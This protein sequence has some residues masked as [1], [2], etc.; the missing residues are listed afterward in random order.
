MLREAKAFLAIW[1]DIDPAMAAEWHRWHSEEHMA[2]RVAIPG[3]LAGRRYMKLA[4]RDQVCFT[5]Y[6]GRDLAVFASP[7]YRARLDAP[8]PWTRRMAPAFRNLVRGACRRIASA[9]LEKGDG[10][11]LLTTRLEG[12]LEGA[13][14]AGGVPAAEALV[15][16]I[17]GLDGMVG[18][19]LGICEPE[20]T[21]RETRERALRSGTAETSFD[22]VVIVEAYDSAMLEEAAAEIESL[23]AAAG[24]GL[25]PL[26][27]QTY[28]LAFMLRA[29]A[30]PPSQGPWPP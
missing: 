5:L 25:R 11:A 6:E 4:A 29:P 2:E 7:A 19:H 14:F 18:A 1:H 27:A 30:G 20:V 10:G 22:G 15:A 17:A 21:E 28:G 12:C 26:A 9:G 3:F 24:L 23:I 8:T 13:E 16:R